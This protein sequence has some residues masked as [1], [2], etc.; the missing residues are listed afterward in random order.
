MAEASSNLS[1]FDGIRYGSREKASNLDTTYTQSRSKGFG[2][3]VKR[4]II[5][6]TYILSSGYYDAYYSKALKVR[7]LIKEEYNKLFSKLDCI[8]IPTTSSPSFRLKAN[9]DD[10]MKMYLS[11]M[12]TVPFNLI[13]S[14]ALNIPGGKTKKNLP[15]G[16]QIVG[17][18]FKEET[19]F[20]FAHSL[21][22]ARL[23]K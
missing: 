15:I 22:R 21:E 10:P 18:S 9:L 3:E 16:F 13:G 19:L 12:F 1:R 17:D 11:D 4:R 20:R 5:T 23:F 6:G 2:P 8:F 14:P 7:R